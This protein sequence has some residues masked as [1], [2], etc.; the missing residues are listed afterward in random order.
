MLPLIMQ[1]V[2]ELA[3]SHSAGLESDRYRLIT[4]FP[5]GGP[6]C[7][8]F[9]AEALEFNDPPAEGDSASQDTIRA[10][11]FFRTTDGLYYDYSYGIRSDEYRLSQICRDF[12]LNAQP[13]TSDVSFRTA[14][15]EKRDAFL[16]RY[17]RSTAGDLG[18]FDF[19]Y[20]SLS[21][22]SWTK[23]TVNATEAARLQAKALDV[24]GDLVETE[25]VKSLIEQIASAN[26]SAIEYQFGFFDVIREWIDPQLFRGKW[27][28]SSGDQVLYGTTD[29]FLADHDDVHLCFPQRFYLVRNCSATT[30]TPTPPEVR[31][32]IHGAA[33]NPVAARRRAIRNELIGQKLAH[34][35]SSPAA[36]AVPPAGLPPA[37]PAPPAPA[38]YVWVPGK[39]DVSGHWERRRAG[40]APTP[41]PPLDESVYK[42]AAMKCRVVPRKP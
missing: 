5:P 17:L 21:P 14:F 15:A 30:G 6:D 34:L 28:F 36:I 3:E 29:P 38:G 40:A 16:N 24:Y 10:F 7:P 20:T 12:F 42:V 13:D 37:T 1:H 18:H 32:H 9:Q 27:A 4:P 25:L 22:I 33:A 11:D 2:R 41:Q 8:D 26:Y 19:R 39:G 23:I 35:A 31:D